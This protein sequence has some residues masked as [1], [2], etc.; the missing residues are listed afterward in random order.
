[1]AVPMEAPRAAACMAGVDL[2][3]KKIL[4]SVIMI[5]D[6]IFYILF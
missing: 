3:R 1:M 6:F 5:I 4:F 2:G